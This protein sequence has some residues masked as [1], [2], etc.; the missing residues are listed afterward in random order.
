MLCTGQMTDLLMDERSQRPH[1]T[2][3]ANFPHTNMHTMLSAPGNSSN[4]D[5]RI[6]SDHYDGSAIL[7]GNGQYNG[8]HHRH[9]APS[10]DPCVASGTNIYNPYL[11]PSPGSRGFPVSI[12]HGS[13]DQF[14]SSSNHGV[15]GVSAD[16]RDNHFIMDGVRGAGKR[17]NAEGIQGHGQHINGLASSSSSVP[18]FNTR[19]LESG[20][21]MI[22]SASFVQPQYRGNN[23]PSI[24]E[25]GHSIVELGSHRSVRNRSGAVGLDSVLAHNHNHLVQGNFIVH[26]LPSGNPWVDQQS[27]NNG[28][29]GGTLAWNH[30]PPLPYLHGIYHHSIF[31]SHFRCVSGSHFMA[32]YCF[33]F[34]S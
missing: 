10:L 1:V 21:S 12:N 22:D 33:I 25:L 2:N 29:D 26:P 6:L 16:I 23:A 31:V 30:G 18:P 4:F 7:Y 17:K 5:V 19:H 20:V 8:P 24:M 28:R 13:S 3:V 27:G 9:P 14:P 15:I 11:T 32:K 34:A